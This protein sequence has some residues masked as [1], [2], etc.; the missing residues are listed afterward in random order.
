LDE[1]GS[2]DRVGL[3]RGE[4]F[5]VSGSGYYAPN[6]R[7]ETNN[8]VGIGGKW[9]K[10]GKWK[11]ESWTDTLGNTLGQGLPPSLSTSPKQS[12][13]RLCFTK[14]AYELLQLPHF[15]HSSLTQEK[16]S[17]L[18]SPLHTD[19]QLFPAFRSTSPAQELSPEEPQTA[20]LPTIQ[21][22]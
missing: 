15:S 9:R 17:S 14:S 13:S 8:K 20:F 5:G 19:Q 22:H 11:V 12:N 2:W 18:M 6:N 7:A 4:G 1:R 21:E 10:L 16:T 3:I